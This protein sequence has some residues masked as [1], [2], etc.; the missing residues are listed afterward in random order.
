MLCWASEDLHIEVQQFLLMLIAMQLIY[1][2][3][4]LLF[5]HITVENHV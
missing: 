1:S 5:Y 4:I 2:M 3:Y